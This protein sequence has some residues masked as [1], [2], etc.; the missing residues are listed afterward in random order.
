MSG[1]LEVRV[2]TSADA[3]AAES[4]GA[5]R[6]EVVG[7]HTDGGRSPEPRLVAEIGRRTRLPMR[8]LLRLREGF[9]TDG[10]EAV[11]LAGLVSA[12]LD[13]GAE[14]VTCG[15]LNGLGEVDTEVLGA[16][17]G[18]TPCPWTFH[19]AVDSCLDADR[20]WKVLLRLP[21]L[22]TIRTAGSARDLEHG[23]DDLLARAR[24]DEAAASRIMADGNVRPEHVPWL[25]RAG[26]RKIHIDRQTRPRES[27]RSAVDEGLVRSWRTLL[28]TE[29]SRLG[30]ARR[31]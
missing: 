5:D 7:S 22:D 21:N 28:D 2:L 14:G 11:R 17:L 23:L 30:Q 12:Y 18:D 1:T 19:R 29:V 24:S 20:A 13:A 3:L 6:L 31:G 27:L 10:G 8:P 26:V 16:V 15:F 9:G 25:V 4:G